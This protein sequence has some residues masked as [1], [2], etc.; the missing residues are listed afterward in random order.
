MKRANS[1]TSEYKEIMSKSKNQKQ[2]YSKIQ[3][4][5]S[6]FDEWEQNLISRE[7][8][9]S[10]NINPIQPIIN[11]PDIEKDDEF[12]SNEQLLNNF[13]MILNEKEQEIHKL[14]ASIEEKEKTIIRKNKE[15]KEL[16]VSSENL[17]KTPE[18]M[19]LQA[20]KNNKACETDHNKDFIQDFKNK[21]NQ[22]IELN[23]DLENKKIEVINMWDEV[24]LK[25]EI[26]EEKEKENEIKRKNLEAKQI[27]YEKLVQKMNKEKE[28]FFQTQAF[29]SEG[30][31]EKER[32][33]SEKERELYEKNLDLENKQRE[34]YEKVKKIYQ[35]IKTLNQTLK[36]PNLE[37]L[38]KDDM[39]VN[40]PDN[41]NKAN[42]N[43]DHFSSFNSSLNR[44]SHF[45]SNK[46][47][48]ENKAFNL[49]ESTKI[50]DLPTFNKI[51]EN[52]MNLL[53]ENS[54]EF[55]RNSMS[56]SNNNNI[57]TS[58]NFPYDKTFCKE[59]N[60]YLPLQGKS[61]NQKKTI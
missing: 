35:M 47:E 60:L 55:I 15:I 59:L 28:H 26:L 8:N 27:E 38:L 61:I 23:K 9:L 14:R 36:N 44:N 48:E 56:F 24:L 11:E 12:S 46:I 20:Q 1:Q 54:F 49:D 51:G 21:E 5:M 41:E 37:H 39:F 43:N 45:W 31:K 19:P 33:I 52:D 13:K 2:F 17:S 25:A 10:F 57:D 40:F 50:N 34:F 58:E 53:N 16:Q 6:Y 42:T 29:R 30:D 32:K 22:L 7:E 3:K 18:L 4:L